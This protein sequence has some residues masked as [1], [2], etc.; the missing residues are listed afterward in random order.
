[1]SV[2]I[3]PTIGIEGEKEYRKQVN[4]LITQQKTFSSEMKKVES[5]FDKNT[6]A[7]EKSR[8]K[9]EVLT[10]Q[11]SKQKE[12]V[13]E[14]EK[15]LDAAKKKYPENSTEVQRWEQ[16]VNNAR[17]ELNK[18]NKELDELPNG[19]QAAGETMKNIGGSMK[20]VGDTLTKYVT[21]PLTA[22]AGA[23]VAAWNEVDEG[24][25]IVTKK[26]GATGQ[27]LEDLQQSALNIASTIP[28]SF[29]TA[30]EAVGEVNTRF[31]LT[32][33]ALEDLSGRFIKFADLNDTDVSDSI[34]KVQKLMAAYGV[35]TEEAGQILDALNKTG[36]D[37]GISMDTLEDSMIRNASSLKGMG[38]DA[39]AAAG[40]LGQVETSGADTSV[41]MSGLGKAFTNA[42]KAGKS[43]PD[44]LKDFQ[45]TMSSSA[46][47]QEKL[48]A[49]CDLFGSKAGKA[50]YDACKTGSLSFE[51][52][53]SDA[54]T[55]MGN[56]ETT[57]E[58]VKDP[59]DNFKTSLNRAKI[60]GSKLGS[61][62]LDIAA[63]A[64]E[65]L[66]DMAKTAGEWFN[67]LSKEQQGMIGK[68]VLFAIG[69]GPVI[70]TLGTLAESASTVVTALGSIPGAA[71]AISSAAL[72]V[73][74]AIGAFALLKSGI[75]QAH[76]DAIDSV[77]GLR[78][79]L[80]N[81]ASSTDALNNATEKMR[82][83][84][85]ETSANISEI[86]NKA[87]TAQRLT[88]ELYKLDAASDK[89]A[90]DQARMKAIVGELNALYPG[91][92]LAIDGAT[93]A[94]NKGKG[95]VEEY[96]EQTKNLALAEAY[97]TG[98]KNAYND[99]ADAQMKLT[100]AQDAQA[101][102]L[103]VY[104]R[105]YH[106]LMEAEAA[107][108]KDVQTGLPVYTA[109]M[110]E[111]KDAVDTSRESLEK[112][113]QTVRDNKKAVAE[114]ETTVGEWEDAYDDLTKSTKKSTGATESQTDATEDAADATDEYADAMSDASIQTV[115]M[116]K[117]QNSLV[118]A[119][120]STANM[121]GK[122]K[123]ALKE[124]GQAA[125]QAGQDYRNSAQQASES[126]QKQI[127]LFD[128]YE[129]RAD[130][131]IETLKKNAQSRAEAI[132]N[133]AE[134]L[135]KLI[136][137]AE[138]SGSQTAKDYVAAIAE[139]GIG[140]A[141]EVEVLANSANEDLMFLVDQ[142]YEATVSATFAGDKAAYAMN[143]FMTEEQ[144]K[145]K[146]FAENISK[147][148]SDNV[149]AAKIWNGFKSESKKALDGQKTYWSNNNPE[150]KVKVNIPDSKTLFGKKTDIQ[151]GIG[152][153]ST[154]V[155]VGIPSNNTLQGLRSNV[156]KPFKGMSATIK[157]ETSNAYNAGRAAARAIKNAAG[158]V[159]I[160]VAASKTS[161]A[162]RP[163]AT[164][165]FVDEPTS[166]LIGEAGPEV[167]IPLSSQ[168]RTRALD[169]YEQ[170]G[171]ILG[172]NKESIG[173]ASVSLPDTQEK[174]ISILS[175]QAGIDFD[176]LYTVVAT[177]ARY[178]MMSANIKLIS[179][180]R[181][182]ARTLRDMGVQF[183]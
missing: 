15:G 63:P 128:A 154:S 114:A 67:S 38:M 77:E 25:D 156:I 122:A 7:M 68:G 126:I 54:S 32:G 27:A 183:A 127:G 58:N 36:Q 177:A 60:A 170:T 150:T 144:K 149:G 166:A 171:E 24:L 75:D 5:E 79:M 59:A 64:I 104:T 45:K 129:K 10:K 116:Q 84:I 80:E 62:L 87:D 14:L 16:A 151:K 143:G 30:G 140:C 35:S 55:Y 173:M 93:G 175:K 78:G 157:I 178:G 65:E 161:S 100:A 48:T 181:E 121:V 42:A 107:A 39:Y 43:L 53:S 85:S 135:D 98:I 26:T 12:I 6:S 182:V 174:T 46:S 165:G 159:Y 180:D 82:A 110:N 23:S 88:D 160:P 142:N 52:L 90:E 158:T 141:E 145:F 92:E 33:T 72:P 69:V 163:Y 109:E 28:T 117:K 91:L 20:T 34:D 18:M 97:A 108:E 146:T 3:G 4:N 9:S 124:A 66:G 83:T 112:Q 96:V 130:V 137:W 51:T 147:G 61:T 168:M 40:F 139:M 22:L 1:M 103:D 2:K 17:T 162:D 179:K 155:S 57:F 153:P 164:G 95:E 37:T 172:I 74:I 76:Q 167:V 148:I 113:N 89:T 86:N 99:L 29:E 94:L 119:L 105:A 81:T 47:E 13:K 138:E 115:T 118:S 44:A 102:A 70:S 71:G 136:K 73:G 56:V 176:K 8:K 41:V 132:K 123:N 131:N 50:I 152:T 120:I 169:L 21:V 106:D 134:N 31:G 11:I 19:L 101:Q 49:A 125:N 133:Y 111:L